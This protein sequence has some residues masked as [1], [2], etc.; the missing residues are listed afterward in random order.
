MELMMNN[1]KLALLSS[2]IMGLAISSTC[3]KAADPVTLNITGNIVAS[4]CQVSSDSITKSIDLGQNIQA[5]ALQTGG[6]STTWVPFTINLSSCPAGTTTAIMTMHGTADSLNPADQYANT[7]TA[8]NVAVQLQSQTAVQLGDGK[9][10]TGNVVSSA[11]TYNLQARAFTQNG[12]VTPGSIIS[13]IT[14]TFV[15]N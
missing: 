13:V 11:V 15:Y 6:S 4:P 10:I 9:S 5:S 8:T 14:A 3:I 12:S 2:V 7:G 1:I